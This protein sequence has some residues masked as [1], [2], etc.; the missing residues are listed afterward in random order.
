MAIRDIQHEKTHSN[1]RLFN[2][3]SGV[4]KTTISTNV[5]HYFAQRGERVL[6]VD[7]DPQCNATQLMLATDQCEEIYGSA[8][9][10][11][12]AVR[13]SLN[14]TVYSLF[15]PLREGEPTIN[16]SITPFR[17]ERFCVNVLAVHPMLSQIEDVMNEAWFNAL[18]G[19]TGGF[20]RVHWAGQHATALEDANLYDVV[21]FAVRPSL[22]PFNRTVLL[23][24][25]A[26]VTPTFTDLFSYHA[27]GNLS[28]WFTEWT[29]EYSE[30]VKTNKSN[31]ARYATEID[32]K[33][34]KLRLHGHDGRNLRYLGYTT[35][36]YK[37]KKKD[38]QEILVGAY[39]LFRDKFGTAANT[40]ADSL[41]AKQGNY[42]LGHIPEM[43]SMPVR[44]QN[45]HAPIAD[46]QPKDGVNGQQK[47]QHDS[48]VSDIHKVAE[49]IYNQI[50]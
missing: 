43:A 50:L 26:F 15:V 3:K 30:M 13:S 1:H 28:R 47:N 29:V 16:A 14:K 22:D 37:K 45:A 12:A 27:F 25:D 39:E 19:K 40:I 6:Y 18:S 9:N 4:G 24:C 7:C 46:L 5:A 48:Y 21:F 20:R 32:E 35:Q 8:D 10:V 41:G 23:G 49:N 42:L 31:W 17:S 33:V 11:D 34:R 2:N 38:G 44:A 36:E